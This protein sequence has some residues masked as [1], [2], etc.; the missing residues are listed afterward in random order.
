MTTAAVVTAQAKINLLLRVLARETSGYHSIETIFQRI[1]RA[2]ELRVRVATGR[3][4]DVVRQLKSTGDLGPVEKNLAWRAAVAYAEA[5][6]W[7][8]GFAIELQ[9]SIPVGAGLGGGSADAGAVLR[10]LDALSPRPLGPKLVEI[11]APLGADVPFMTIEHPTVLAWGRGERM[12]ALP[13]LEPR[14]VLM[15]TPPFGV[16]TAD[17]YGWLSASRGE[18]QPV[19]MLLDPQRPLSWDSV[20]AVATNDFQDIVAA[21]HPQIAELVDEF[22]SIGASVAMMSGS[23]SAVFGIF[24]EWDDAA[25]RLHTMPS[26]GL[27]LDRTPTSNEVPPVRLV[28]L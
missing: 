22:Q 15:F 12:F 23:G 11:A 24:D 13:P 19:G 27:W 7:P 4:L 28:E 18:Y 3:S 8:S 21:R 26:N 17:A 14:Q 9:K 2:D 20:A 16:S 25:A 5:T 10:A 1:Q 6:G